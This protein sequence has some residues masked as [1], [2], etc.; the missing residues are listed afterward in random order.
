MWYGLWRGFR[1]GEIMQVVVSFFWGKVCRR[2]IGVLQ[3]TESGKQVN[4]FVS[5]ACG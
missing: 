2:I 1:Y 4:A 3:R 5:C